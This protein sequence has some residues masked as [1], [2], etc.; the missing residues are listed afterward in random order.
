MFGGAAVAL[1]AH[2]EHIALWHGLVSGHNSGGTSGPFSVMVE[3][4]PYEQTWLNVSLAIIAVS[5]FSSDLAFSRY[6]QSRA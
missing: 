6:F 5:K 4:P 3:F 2:L 1:I